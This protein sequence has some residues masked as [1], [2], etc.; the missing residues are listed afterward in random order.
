MTGFFL[1]AIGV[2]AAAAIFTGEDFIFKIIYLLAGVLIIGR[3]WS[4]R[5]VKGIQFSR[6][7][8]RRA[9]P[10]QKVQV[11][12]E[13]ENRSR[14]PAV[15]LRIHEGLPIEISPV[16][17]FQRVVSLGPKEKIRLEYTLEPNQRGYFPGGAAED[18]NR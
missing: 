18:H 10:E 4:S 2:L 3:G 15:W 11:Q 9:F 13:I 6:Q 1:L 5:V 16:R 12:L 17:S 8:T 14:L 7:F